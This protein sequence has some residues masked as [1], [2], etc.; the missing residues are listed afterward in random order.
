MLK[1]FL[2]DFILIG[3]LVTCSHNHAAGQTGSSVIKVQDPAAPVKLALPPLRHLPEN[4]LARTP[5]MGWVS[6]N[7]FG[8]AVDEKLIRAVAD[9][10]VT[11]GMRDAGYVYLESNDGWQSKRETG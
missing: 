9:S 8:L 4:G 6:Y 3:L 1:R 7:K 10:L 2:A 11:T 5:P